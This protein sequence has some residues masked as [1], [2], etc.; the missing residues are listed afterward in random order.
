MKHKV[1]ACVCMC[2][3]SSVGSVEGRG[4]M[5]CVTVI[6]SSVAFTSSSVLRALAVSL[7]SGVRVTSR[8]C[9]LRETIRHHN[10]LGSSR[11]H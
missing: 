3:E 10:L 11:R 5:G 2:V 6:A 8:L 9:V 7:A 4:V 1:R